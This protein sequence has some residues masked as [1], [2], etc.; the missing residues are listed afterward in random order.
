MEDFGRRDLATLFLDAPGERPAWLA[1]AVGA[2]AELAALEDPGINPP[3]DAAL[4]RAINRR[5]SEQSVVMMH[6][7]ALELEHLAV[8]LEAVLSVHFDLPDSKT[9]RSVVECFATSH[10]FDLR[11]IKFR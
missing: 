11:G 5:R 4:F 6:A 1:R 8:E 7:A 2:A 3:F 10:D 9:S